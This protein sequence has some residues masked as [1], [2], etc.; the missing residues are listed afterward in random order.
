MMMTIH[1]V[2]HIA[3]SI[4]ES[5]SPAVS[6]I[7]PT[8]DALVNA[9][10]RWFR[11]LIGSTVLVALGCAME[12]WEASVEI[13][14]W[15]WHKREKPFHEDETRLSIPMSVMGLVFVIIGVTLEGYFEARQAV[16]ETAI[17]QYDENALAAAT[18]DAGAAK[19]LPDNPWR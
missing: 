17:R 3:A 5:L 13:L 18:R 19:S 8:R 6:G 9:A 10:D 12:I 4:S 1:S 2:S 7:D 11:W 14:Q 15:L 16:A